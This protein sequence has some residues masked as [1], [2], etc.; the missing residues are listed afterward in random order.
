MKGHAVAAPARLFADDYSASGQL[1]WAGALEGP[2]LVSA[3]DEDRPE[4]WW[5]FVGQLRFDALL[6]R[7]LVVPDSH[8]L[9]GTFFTAIQPKQLAVALARREEPLGDLVVPI[10]FRLRAGTVAQ[11]L[12]T[13]LLAPRGRLRRFRFKTIIPAKARETLADE[14]SKRTHADLQHRLGAYRDPPR[15]ADAIADL[16]LDCLREAD[17]DP[18]DAIESIERLRVSWRL[19]VEQE[20]RGD[21]V[22]SGYATDVGFE[23]A[24]AIAHE[25]LDRLRDGLE[26]RPAEALARVLEELRHER[27]RSAITKLLDGYRSSADDA[28][29]DQ[30]DAWV[31][32]IR[33][34]AIAHQHGARFA[35]RWAEG[36]PFGDL[37]RLAESTLEQERESAPRVDLP[38]DI[39][40]LLA[41]LPPGRFERFCDENLTP[42]REWW[43]RGDL[44]AFEA[45]A[46][47]LAEEL[48][49][50]RRGAQAL[51]LM[52]S[53][54][55]GVAT[56]LGAYVLGV[57]APLAGTVGT[58]V[59]YATQ[60]GIAAAEA[61][62]RHLL[63]RRIVEHAREALAAR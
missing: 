50:K 10:E 30:I 28:K 29:I 44:N 47:R 49:P 2:P 60:L 41:D 55:A 12:A 26:G 31:S 1:A 38:G 13:F 48:R 20:E 8:L 5:Q 3:A 4:W 63:A 34:R 9:D 59:T 19:W 40:Q 22:R 57:P 25:P 33:Y 11:T 46:S 51:A 36:E 18:P 39:V 37:Q 54:P 43:G 27:S 16:L 56:G 15:P 35:Q 21:L 42:L 7:R 45:V 24:A 17:F 52:V 32:R 61:G 6:F 14:L 23:P 53:T 58:T 62:P